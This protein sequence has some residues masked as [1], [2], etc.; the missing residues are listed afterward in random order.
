MFVFLYHNIGIP[1]L[2]YTA[3]YQ[4]LCMCNN[5]NSMEIYK[6]D[7]P[8]ILESLN[9]MIDALLY[10]YLYNIMLLILSVL[11]IGLSIE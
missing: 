2:Y 9:A 10:V 8:V 7:I 11:S 5:Y 6:R 3:I 4:T 1:I